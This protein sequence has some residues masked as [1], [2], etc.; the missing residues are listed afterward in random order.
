MQFIDG[1]T[2]K[3]HPKDK[4]E[5]IWTDWE[6]FAQYAFNKSHSTCYALVAY[7]TG[8][9]KAHYPSEFMAAVLNHAGVIEKITFFMEECKR[10]GLTVLGPDINESLKGFAVNKK[11]EIRFGLGGLKGVGENAIENIILE[12]NKDG[13]YKNIF[14]FIKRVNQRA[15]NKKSLESLAYSG[16]FDC[17]PQLH[18]AQYFNIPDGERI[19][20]LE[21]IIGYGQVQQTLTTD[22]TNTL[23]G[24]LAQVMDVQPPKIAACEQWTLTEKLEHEKDVTGM[25]MSGHPLDHF[26]FELKYYGIMQLSDFNE[27][28]DSTTLTASNLGRV[29]KVAGL[30]I[31]VQ[32]RITKTGKNFGSF[33]IEDFSGKTDF[34]L[35]SEDYVKFQNYLEKG[36]NILITGFFRNRFK[37][38]NVFEFKATSMSLL[39]TVKQTMTKNIELNLHPAAI[40]STFVDFVDQNV[41]HNPGKAMLRFNIIEPLENLKVSLYT[42][43]KGFTMNDEMAEFLWNNPDVEVNVGLSN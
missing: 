28:K 1:A 3:G 2:V 35:W 29:F 18:R 43:E 20:T 21:K 16:T 27:Y 17:F 30:V 37:Q 42:Y 9:L 23:F 40:S 19:S 24:D 41:K 4:L 14:D 26:K 39:E 11:G 34:I 7:Q 33:V 8:Y 12:R 31:D 38:E 22:T 36:Q 5:K 15:V 32:H 13:L 6:A 25:F 10:M